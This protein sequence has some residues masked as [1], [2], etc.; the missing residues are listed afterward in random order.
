MKQKVKAVALVVYSLLMDYLTI[1]EILTFDKHP[2]LFAV[3]IAIAL[4]ALT[5]VTTYLASIIWST[6]EKEN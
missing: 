5:I 3:L 2:G 1:S 6:N 4:F